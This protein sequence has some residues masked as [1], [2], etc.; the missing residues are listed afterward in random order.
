MKKTFVV[1]TILVLSTPGPPAAL[2]AKTL[3]LPEVSVAVVDHGSGRPV[4]GVDVALLVK[5]KKRH[6]F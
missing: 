2:A 6:D 4:A 5:D 1:S 3:V